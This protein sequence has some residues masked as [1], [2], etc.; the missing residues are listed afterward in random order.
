MFAGFFELVDALGVSNHEFGTGG[1]QLLG[2]LG[3]R[4][5]RICGGGDGAEHGGSHKR[6]NKF[7]RVV[8][9][10]HNDIAFLNSKFRESGGGFE[11]EEVGVGVGIGFASGAEDQTGAVG[12][13]REV[14]KAVTVKREVVGDSNIGKFG[15]ESMG[16]GGGRR[17]RGGEFGG[18]IGILGN[19]NHGC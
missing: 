4:V 10:N 2:N 11:G 7:G 17:G 8:E 9:K 1:L 16:C 13:F 5:V 12:N 3:R 15:S 19:G 14:L 6:E 18:D